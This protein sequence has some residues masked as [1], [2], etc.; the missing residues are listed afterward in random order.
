M[1]K[2]SDMFLILVTADFDDQAYSPVYK[3]D[4]FTTVGEKADRIMV[5]KLILLGLKVP[6][7]CIRE[8]NSVEQLLKA[9]IS[10]FL[11]FYCT[12]SK[13]FMLFNFS[14]FVFICRVFNNP[15]HSN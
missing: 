9:A 12:G 5:I 1:F 15:I 11:R 7:Y 10:E 2:L 8:A 3:A 13:N 14:T 6:S 4:L